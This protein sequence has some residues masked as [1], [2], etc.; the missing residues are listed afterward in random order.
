MHVRAPHTAAHP[1]NC[2]N[3]RLSPVVV[4]PL[5][6]T[7]ILCDSPTSQR[8]KAPQHATALKGPNRADAPPR[9]L[10]YQL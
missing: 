2:N 4:P 3:A 5:P 6:V 10:R 1:H 8:S 7:A 9:D